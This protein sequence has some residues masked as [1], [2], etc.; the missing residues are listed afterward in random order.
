[1]S[2]HDLGP[3]PKH[4]D[5]VIH[6]ILGPDCPCGNYT[7]KAPIISKAITPPRSDFFD[8]RGSNFQMAM[9]R[10]ASALIW[11]IQGSDTEARS[12]AYEDQDAMDAYI[13]WA[14]ES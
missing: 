14:L 11:T 1:M 2:Y 8:M 13:Q 10:W 12:W 9:R 5:T 6:G 4:E 3:G 7:P